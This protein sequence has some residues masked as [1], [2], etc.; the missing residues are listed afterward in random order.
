[1]DLCSRRIVGWALAD[2]LRSSLVEEAM[3]KALKSRQCSTGLIFHSDRGSQYGSKTIRAFIKKAQLQQSMSGRANPYD[4]AAM[5]SL[6]GTLKAELMQ[7]GSFITKR[8]CR[9]RNCRVY[10]LLQHAAQALLHSIPS[11]ITIRKNLT[12]AV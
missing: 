4:N 1:M 7:D 2:H 9:A 10:K 5:E 6:M 11:P 8:R 3:E 12:K